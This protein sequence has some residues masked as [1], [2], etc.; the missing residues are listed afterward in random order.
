[1]SSDD[2]ALVYVNGNYVGENPGV[3]GA[4]TSIGHRRPLG[5][6]LPEHLLCGPRTGGAYL[7]VGGLQ[8]NGVGPGAIDLGHDGA[9]L[10]RARLAGYR[11]RKTVG[12]A[13]RA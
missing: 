5:I 3:R 6:G 11:A 2:D 12:L 7:A 8:R 1:V 13:V 9:G 4:E 10:R